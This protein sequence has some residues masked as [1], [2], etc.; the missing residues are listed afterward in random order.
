MRLKPNVSVQRRRNGPNLEAVVADDA[1]EGDDGVDDG[2]ERQ[3]RLHVTGALFQEVVQRALFVIIFPTFLQSRP[4]FLSAGAF[5]Q[6]GALKQTRT[7][8]LLLTWRR[9]G[10]LQRK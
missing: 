5:E 7:L 9:V 6:A 4:I 1:E 8:E 2:E 10:H 3:G